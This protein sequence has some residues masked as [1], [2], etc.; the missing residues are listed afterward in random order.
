M[1]SISSVL[2]TTSLL[3]VL[4]GLYG[5]LTRKNLI[6][7]IISLDIIDLGVNIF[8]VTIGYIKDGKAPIFLLGSVV[9]LND[10]ASKMVDPLPQ[11][12]VLTAIVIGFGVT[13]VALTLIMRLYEKTGTVMVSDLR[14]LK[15]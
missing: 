14:G 15:W 3:L 5:V 6:R 9:A 13:A 8:L 2:Y 12:L 1:I 11:S 10:Q 4:L 7:V